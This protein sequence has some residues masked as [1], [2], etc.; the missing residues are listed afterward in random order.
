MISFST[1]TIAFESQMIIIILLIIFDA[2]LFWLP[3]LMY[4]AKAVETNLIIE[5][6]NMPKLGIL[7]WHDICNIQ[8]ETSEI[9]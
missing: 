4:G 7:S 8:N 3:T 1:K 6:S 2:F 5:P 9:L